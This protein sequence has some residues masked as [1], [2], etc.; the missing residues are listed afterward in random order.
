MRRRE[1]IGFVGGVLASPIAAHAQQPLRRRRI[2]Y[3]HPAIPN[4]LSQSYVDAWAGALA[5]LGWVEGSTVSIEKHWAEGDADRLQ[6]LVD[7]A[8][9]RKVDLLLT[10][11]QAVFPASE[12]TKRFLSS[13]SISKPTPSRLASCRASDDPAPTSPACSL[14]HRS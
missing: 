7:E 3:L 5:T 2:A 14:T 13:P 12:A 9:Q 10:I 6:K 4:P 1:F 8:V 11:G